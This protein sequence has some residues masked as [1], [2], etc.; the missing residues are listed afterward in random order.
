MLHAEL[1]IGLFS[2]MRVNVQSQ[3]D[4]YLQCKLTSTIC[5]LKVYFYYG[6][7]SSA[8]VVYCHRLTNNIKQK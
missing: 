5:N 4:L 2:V 1:C 7:F 6:V 8:K 3:N